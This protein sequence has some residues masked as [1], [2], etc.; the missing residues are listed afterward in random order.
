MIKTSTLSNAHAITSVG[1]G[2]IQSLVEITLSED[3]RSGDLTAELIDPEFQTE[4]QL[5]TRQDAV[6][7]GTDWFEEVFRQLDTS[8]RVEWHAADGD[9]ILTDQAVCRVTGRARPILTGERSAIN[10][11]QTLSG[12]ATE[13]SRY[14]KLL[15]GTGTRLLDTRKTV[16]GLR[17]AQKYAVRCG[18][19]F[20]HRMGLHDGILIK[21]NHLRAD[22][23]VGEIL[24]RAHAVAPPRALLEIEVETL[25]EFE[26]A[27]AAGAKRILLDNF[28]VADLECAV[29]L[30][31]GRAKLEAS[32]NV[33]LDN[34]RAIAETGVDFI[35]VGSITKHVSAVD[36]SLQF[37][38]SQ[39]QH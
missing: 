5:I 6:L 29:A 19:G 31:H 2:E 35:S 11:L 4:A 20:N 10:L 7:C 8:V 27:L 3:I 38:N 30:N 39:S 23:G 15:V 36:F 16:P 22:E 9:E 14:A 34:I 26:A 17:A 28:A 37:R 12:T 32:G 25:G 13:T 24:A 18:G 33:R 1:R 21:E